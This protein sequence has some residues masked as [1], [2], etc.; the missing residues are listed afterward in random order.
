MMLFIFV[1]VGG[2]WIFTVTYQVRLERQ[3]PR[4]AARALVPPVEDEWIDLTIDFLLDL[5]SAVGRAVAITWDARKGLLF[6]NRSARQRKAKL[7]QVK[8]ELEY[9]RVARMA[10]A[11]DSLI[12]ETAKLRAARIEL[13]DRRA[14]EV[15]EATEKFVAETAKLR[16]A[17]VE[18]EDATATRLHEAT[19]NLVAETVKLR[20]VRIELEQQRNTATMERREDFPAPTTCRKKSLPGH[21]DHGV[22]D[23]RR[24][25]NGESPATFI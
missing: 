11:T 22:A 23:S 4:A 3:E 15:L 21:R 2:L 6:A 1:P 8:A 9:R 20:T 7:A 10:L 18:L 19:G 14:T 12:T 5:W 24:E 25:G 16:T 17:R 13:E